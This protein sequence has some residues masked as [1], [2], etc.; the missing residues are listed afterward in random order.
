MKRTP[1]AIS[2]LPSSRQSDTC[3]NTKS[4]SI[5]L[6]SKNNC[7]ILFK[8]STISIVLSRYE[9]GIQVGTYKFHR[10]NISISDFYARMKGFSGLSEFR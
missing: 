9:L 7:S 1:G 4:N 6:T 8:K 10:S 2:A 5:D 3:K